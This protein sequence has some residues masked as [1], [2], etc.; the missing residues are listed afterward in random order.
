VSLNVDLFQIEWATRCQSESLLSLR[1]GLQESLHRLGAMT[2]RLKIDNSSA[3]TH[4]LGP[5]GR[6]LN[7]D[8]FWRA[9]PVFFVN[10]YARGVGQKCRS[11]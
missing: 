6:D 5:G 8:A 2:E 9:T 3:A 10:R 1:H 11:P 4:W 7:A